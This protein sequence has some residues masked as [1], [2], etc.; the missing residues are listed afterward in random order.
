MPLTG[1]G[2]PGEEDVPG[3]VL[4][5]AFQESDVHAMGTIN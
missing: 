2:H 1:A 3:L 5:R 4:V